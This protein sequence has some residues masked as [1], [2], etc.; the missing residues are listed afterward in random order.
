MRRFLSRRVF[1]LT[2][3]AGNQNDCLGKEVEV[4]FTARVST[5]GDTGWPRFGSG[6]VGGVVAPLGVAR[7]VLLSRRG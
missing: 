3:H 5:N 7:V 2:K 1:L 4:D 6:C